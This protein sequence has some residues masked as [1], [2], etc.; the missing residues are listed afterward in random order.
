MSKTDTNLI[1]DGSGAITSTE[2]ADLV[3]RFKSFTA[4]LKIMSED[5]ERDKLMFRREAHRLMGRAAPGTTRVE[6]SDGDKGCVMVSDLDLDK[7]GN[8]KKIPLTLL[9]AAEQA[10]VNIEGKFE[11]TQT[12]AISSAKSKEILGAIADSEEALVLTGSMVEWIRAAFKSQGAELP[13]SVVTFRASEDITVTE[14]HQLTPA[15]AKEL[16]AQ[17]RKVAATGEKLNS[18][19]YDAMKALLEGGIKDAPVNVR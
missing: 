2:L 15:A 19:Q 17:M 5:V 13:A 16:Q 1:P 12:M 9:Q 3:R 8:R 6:F 7:A 11:T 4:T 10:G 18:T 14:T